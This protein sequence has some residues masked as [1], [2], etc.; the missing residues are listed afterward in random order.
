MRRRQSTAVLVVLV[1]LGAA[2]L[3]VGCGGEIEI[4]TKDGDSAFASAAKL[5][6]GWPAQIALP[7][8]ATI[9]SG[10]R[11]TGDDKTMMNVAGTVQGAGVQQVM[12]HLTAQF[13]GWKP[14]NTTNMG[15]GE[16]QVR[17]EVF[18]RGEDT[19][20]VSVTATS[21]TGSAKFNIGLQL[22]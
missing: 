12:D 16:N 14:V 1:L 17:G 4:T 13:A 20:N 8:G 5:P 7:A 15:S 21:G 18:E 9:T 22:K 6:E 11:I 3:G 10:T 2:L 19:A